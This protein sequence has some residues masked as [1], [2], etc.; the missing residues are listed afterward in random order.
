MRC[1]ALTPSGGWGMSAIP[2]LS[3]EDQISGERAKVARVTTHASMPI[4]HGGRL[5]RGDGQIAALD[6]TDQRDLSGTFERH[7]EAIEGVAS[8]HYERGEANPLIRS[9]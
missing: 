8:N 7:R 9:G 4:R 6:G 3:G 2:P 5:A 1:P